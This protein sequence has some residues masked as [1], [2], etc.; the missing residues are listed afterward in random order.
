MA[1]NRRNIQIADDA[2]ITFNRAEMDPSLSLCKSKGQKVLS[3]LN[4]KERLVRIAS[5]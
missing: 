1:K 5:E 2:K 3:W 4:D